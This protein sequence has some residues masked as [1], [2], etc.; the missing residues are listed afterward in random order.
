MT[1]RAGC[2]LVACVNN[3]CE[4]QTCIT[5]MDDALSNDF[6]YC[7][8]DY[9][10]QASKVGGLRLSR[11]IGCKGKRGQEDNFPTPILVGGVLRSIYKRGRCA[12][13]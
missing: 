13:N 6:E 1:T 10:K 3:D 4:V 11:Q 9:P 7:P 8:E 12:E 2:S 5:S